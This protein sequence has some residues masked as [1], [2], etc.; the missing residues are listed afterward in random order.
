MN[1]T[2]NSNWNYMTVTDLYRQTHVEFM[3][4][5]NQFFATNFLNQGGGNVNF[6]A[7]AS[8]QNISGYYMIKNVPLKKV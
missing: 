4:K 5:M 6:N 2:S 1:T 3:T 7:T 8:N